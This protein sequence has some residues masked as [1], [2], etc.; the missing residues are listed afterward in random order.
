[1]SSVVKNVHPCAYKNRENYVSHIGANYDPEQ[2]GWVRTICEFHAIRCHR[3]TGSGLNKS[4]PCESFALMNEW[5]EIKSQHVDY[6][7]GLRTIIQLYALRAM[8]Y[9]CTIGTDVREK[10]WVGMNI[11]SRASWS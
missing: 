9:L 7:A 2:T 10:E 11:N 6:F 1:M 8:I 4:H 5:G 3:L